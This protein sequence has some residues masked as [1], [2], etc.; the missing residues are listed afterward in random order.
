MNKMWKRAISSLLTVLLMF[1]LIPIQ[2]YAAVSYE[3][4]E[5]TA[6]YDGQEGDLSFDENDYIDLT[7]TVLT[8]AIS[9]RRD[10]YQKEFMMEN[11]MHLAAVY[12]MAVHFEREGAWEEIDN[13]LVPG[14]NEEGEIYRNKDGMWEVCLPQEIDENRNM[15]LT[16]DGYTLSFR[17]AGEIRKE[18]A[19]KTEE[20]EEIPE[21]TDPGYTEEE[22]DEEGTFETEETTDG[23]DEADIPEDQTSAAEEP[24]EAA[25]AS[26]EVIASEE[27]GEETDPSET[28][29]TEAEPDVTNEETS[30]DTSV[31]DTEE[32]EPASAEDMASEAVT[33]TEPAE[34][35]KED[36]TETEN[37]DETPDNDQ[38]SSPEEVP[39]DAAVPQEEA[40]EITE[41]SPESTE[42]VPEETTEEQVTEEVPVDT[43]D[44]STEDSSSIMKST[45]YLLE[46]S[47]RGSAYTGSLMED[48]L[49]RISSGIRY[50]GV[51]EGTDLR[52]DLISNQLKE[53]V[54]LNEY[55]EGLTGYRY[56][57][58]TGDLILKKEEDG[59]ITAS[60]QEGEEPVFFLPAPVIYDSERKMSSDIEI[61]L[62]ETDEGYL[63]TYSLSEEWL[64]DPERTYPVYLDP[65]IQP[66]QSTWTIQDQSVSEFHS[67]DHLWG[68]V[69]AG[70]FPPSGG[71]G[72]RERIFM[73]FD[74]LPSLTSAAERKAP[75]T[76]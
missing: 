76:T 17:L 57:L 10:K 34:T 54:I 35:D 52:Y 71:G 68:C 55:Q 13:T 41:E 19:E 59:T 30:G 63:L 60:P 29:G 21:D 2:A 1:E 23:S 46:N 38:A 16:H 64:T 40:T 28:A 73:K 53:T 67:L 33:E 15:I 25:E 47:F 51:F 74:S 61:S 45:G 26:E 27:T 49:T 44:M 6:I 22:N 75:G 65:I 58:N 62:E 20:Q 42:T 69:E 11:G 14:T 50:D 56:I 37:I 5:E 18:G 66:V 39:E 70:Y 7:K 31:N 3:E 8:E 72:G 48:I 36:I 9:D 32:E 43:E 24:I 12:P 4:T